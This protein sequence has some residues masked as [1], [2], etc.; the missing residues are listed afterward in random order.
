MFLNI[1]YHHQITV[2]GHRRTSRRMDVTSHF[3]H[4]VINL[5]TKRQHNQHLLV[6][7]WWT[8]Y[9]RRKL[10]LT[11][12]REGET[13]TLIAASIYERL[14]HHIDYSKLETDIGS[15]KYHGNSNATTEDICQDLKQTQRTGKVKLL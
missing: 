13:G 12:D 8:K 5:K 11:S 1:G 4:R 15:R 14:F 3:P 10:I 9:I 7:Y 2:H 6:D